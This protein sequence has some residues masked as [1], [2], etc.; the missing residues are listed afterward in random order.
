M[1]PPTVLAGKC[2]V[3]QS[4]QLLASHSVVGLVF[5][6]DFYYI[7]VNNVTCKVDGDS[8][9]AMVRNPDLSVPQYATLG[10]P[11]AH[12]SGEVAFAAYS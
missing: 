3:V 6:V 7:S 2:F 11:Y 9:V 4:C 12:T 8:H 1:R 10:I 5:E